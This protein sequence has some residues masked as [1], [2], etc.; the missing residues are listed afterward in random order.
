M[1]FFDVVV[2]FAL[3]LTYK[4]LVIDSIPSSV[5]RF[6]LLHI[7]GNFFS[8]NKLKVT[9]KTKSKLIKNHSSN[10]YFF[11]HKFFD[12]RRAIALII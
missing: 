10:N 12:H 2:F 1:I 5:R 9:T 8:G 4:Q 3:H 7:I 11:F 6:L